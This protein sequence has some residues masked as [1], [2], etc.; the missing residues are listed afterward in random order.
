MDRFKR[1]RHGVID[2]Q[3]PTSTLFR[4]WEI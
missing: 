4:T 2:L 3:W 1:V